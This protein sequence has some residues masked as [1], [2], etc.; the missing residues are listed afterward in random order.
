[1]DPSATILQSWMWPPKPHLANQS[2]PHPLPTDVLTHPHPTPTP[3][4]KALQ[5]A[6]KLSKRQRKRLEQI[7]QRKAKEARRSGIYEALA[8]QQLT[9]AT[10]AL[11]RSSKAFSQGVRARA[12][13]Q[14][15]LG[16]CL[17]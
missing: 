2:T 15:L 7:A 6:R 17:A 3:H 1:M 10:Q 16:R 8:K 5:D 12:S 4:A 14:R 9:P 11:L 13:D